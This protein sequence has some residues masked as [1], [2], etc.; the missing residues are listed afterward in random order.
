MII[1]LRRF[2]AIDTTLDINEGPKPEAW[3][4]FILRH[5]DPISSNRFSIDPCMPSIHAS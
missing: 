2:L 3:N 1:F 5:G 4:A